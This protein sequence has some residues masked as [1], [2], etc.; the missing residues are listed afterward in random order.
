MDEF[1]IYSGVLSDAQVA[2]SFAAG[3]DA[4][5]GARPSLTAVRAGSQVQLAWPA[6]AAGF[7]LETALQI[8]GAWLPVTN[9]PEWQNGRAVVNLPLLEN[10]RFFRL[11]K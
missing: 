9:P 11:R 5:L 6:D 3:P 2:A 8:N 10:S 4:L 7:I 1:R